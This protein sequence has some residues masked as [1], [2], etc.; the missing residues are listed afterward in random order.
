MTHSDLHEDGAEPARWTRREQLLLGILA[1][2]SFLVVLDFG[3]IFIPLPSILED[4]GGSLD[5][6]TWVLA[7]FVLIFAVGVLPCAMLAERGKPRR[8][9]I[10]GLA[11]FTVASLACALAPS[12]DFLIGARAVLGLGAAMIE[13]AV[14]ALVAASFTGKRRHRAFRVQGMGFILG[15]LL[16]PVLSGAITT[17]LSWEYIF[18]LNVAAGVALSLAAILVVAEPAANEEPPSSLDTPG[19]VLGS[20]GVG[21]LFFTIIE[22]PRFGWALPLI[23]PLGALAVVSLTLFVLRERRADA[24]LVPVWLFAGRAFSLGNVLRAASEFASI[25]LYFALSHYVQ[26]QLGYSALTMGLLLMMVLVGGLVAAPISESLT[27][28]VDLRW[29]AVP[30][31]LLVAGGTFWAAHLT[32]Q[33]TWT[34]L[35]APLAIA[36]VGFVGQEGP[37]AAARDRAVPPEYAAAA[38]R[39]SYSIFLLGVSLGAAVVAAVWQSQFLSNARTALAETNLAPAVTDELSRLLTDGGVSGQPAATLAGPARELIQQ[40]FA[41]AV[42][43][44]ALSCVAVAALA[45]VA[46]VF[47]RAHR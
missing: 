22:G 9:F 40:S 44:A 23:L 32:P 27:G 39:V 4:L 16:A 34:F 14:F 15:A 19:L 30:G 46:A 35:L 12:M 21:C 1:T 41:D 10:S 25:G 5:E 17:G 29:L 6:V 43:T 2:S 45:C 33:T 28:R 26:V 3:S 37:I 47:L 8:L 20:I 42:N 18:W 13:A 7:A 31:F 24:P 11:V 38:W 36:G